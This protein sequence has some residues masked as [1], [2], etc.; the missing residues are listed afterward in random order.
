M[1]TVVSLV[2]ACLMASYEGRVPPTWI[3]R[4]VENGLA[5]VGVFGTNLAPPEP[6]AP[7][8]APY[9]TL[10]DDISAPLRAVRPNVLIALDEEG[11]D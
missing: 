4:A 5:G 6:A 7:G 2:N 8:A 10:R 9:G 3:R 1:S 11:G